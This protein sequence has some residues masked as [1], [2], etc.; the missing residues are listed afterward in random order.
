[1][2]NFVQDLFHLFLSPIGLVL[3]AM[4]DSSMLF[5][6]PM[7][8][9]TTVVILAART[10]RLFF[11]FPLLATAGSLA[12]SAVT[13]WIGSKIG[14]TSVENWVPQR[15]QETIRCKGAIALAVPALLPPPFPLTPFVLACGA[16]SVSRSRFFIT[17]G[18]MRLLRFGTL[19]LLGRLYGRRILTILQAQ[20]VKTVV[21]LL[22]AL[23]LTGTAYT[24]YRLAQKT[25]RHQ[26]TRS[27][28]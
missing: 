9:D 5:F 11:I 24:I 7:A 21:G 12:G 6:M 2:P 18:V 23:A 26:T 27:L 4:L 16:L 8:V 10:P 15:I 3:L 20:A 13:F 14:E 1:M 25:R 17:M 22:F 19:S 28:P